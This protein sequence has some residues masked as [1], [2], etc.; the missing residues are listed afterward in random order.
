MKEAIL[1]YGTTPEWAFGIIVFVLFGLYYG[2][3]S[4]DVAFGKGLLIG[5]SSNLMSFTVFGC[6]LTLFWL[7]LL[8]F[9][10]LVRVQLFGWAMLWFCGLQ[11]ASFL[12]SYFAL[13]VIRK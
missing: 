4:D 13:K 8:P 2:A 5:L 3:K 1:T 10:I 9:G 6:V 12:L 11:T 7:L